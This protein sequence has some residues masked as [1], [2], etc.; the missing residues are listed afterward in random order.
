VAAFVPGVAAVSWA[1]NAKSDPVLLQTRHYSLLDCRPTDGEVV[2]GWSFADGKAGQKPTSQFCYYAPTSDGPVGQRIFLA[3]E[4]ALL[5]A[6][7]SAVKDFDLLV[8][9]CDLIPAHTRLSDG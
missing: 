6:P 3:K 5:E 2:S 1:N 4:G 9:K 8:S 7:R